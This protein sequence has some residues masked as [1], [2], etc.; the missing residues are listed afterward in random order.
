MQNRFHIVLWCALAAAVAGIVGPSS[1]RA[2]GNNPVLNE[3]WQKGVPMGAK[4]RVLPPLTMPDGLNAAGQKAVVEKI[5]ALKQGAPV[6]FDQFTKD[7]LNGPYVL[8]IDAPQQPPQPGHSIDLWFVVWGNLAKITAPAFLKQQFALDQNDRIDVLKP[9]NLPM[10]ITP[11][12]Q[13]PAGTGGEW[14]AH[15][16]FTLISNDA[17]VRVEGT[18]HVVETVTNDSG[19]M[20]GIVD[21]RFTQD[22]KYP[23]QWQ[24]ILRDQNGRIQKGPNGQPQ[25]GP[26]TPYESAGGYMK[27]TKLVKPAGALFVEYHLVYDEP[28]GWFNGR[29][30]LRAKLRAKTE[31]DVRSFRKQVMQANE[32]P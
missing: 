15:G 14:Y 4:F 12:Q 25:L 1:I 23:N 27:V 6:N 5:L 18:A 17:R 24:P 22:Q 11:P 21:P 7:N 20:A 13:P 29:D 3:L 16:I 2:Q 28:Q 31:G 8:L 26:P 30:L 19:T 32:S 9:A 10:G